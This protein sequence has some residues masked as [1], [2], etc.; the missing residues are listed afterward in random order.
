[1]CRFGTP[2]EPI[3]HESPCQAV[4]CVGLAR[5]EHQTTRRGERFVHVVF[6]SINEQSKRS[7]P[8]HLVNRT[9]R[10]RGADS[11]RRQTRNT[12]LADVNTW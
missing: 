10:F 12:S 11:R 8:V 9:C 4:R 1:M 2:G 7:I 5:G 3:R 6:I